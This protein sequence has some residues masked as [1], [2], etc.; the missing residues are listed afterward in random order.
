MSDVDWDA[1]YVAGF[2]PWDLGGPLPLLSD[3]LATGLLGEPG[4]V[5]APGAG[6]GHD[7]GALAAAG[8]DTTVVDISATAVDY[9]TEH[10][11]DVRVVLGDAL[12]PAFVLAQTGGPV[13]LWWDHTFFCALPPQVRPRLA[14]VAAAVVR[15]GGLLASGVFPIDKPREEEGPPWSYAPEDLESLLEGFE[16]VHTG[17]P[18]HLNPSFSYHHRLVIWRRG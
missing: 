3:A 11:P 18:V 16:R 12:D 7:A 6:R 9:A 17:E 2:T 5:F 10:Y 13:D 1:W 8:W 4:T 14:A 15:P